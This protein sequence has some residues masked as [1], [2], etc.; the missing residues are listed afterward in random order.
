LGIYE[1]MKY[2]YTT[3]DISTV[4]S[5]MISLLALLNLLI[6]YIILGMLC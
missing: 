2:R 4:N 3:F 6:G 1:N 5:Q